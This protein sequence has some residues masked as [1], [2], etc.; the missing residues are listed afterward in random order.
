VKHIFKKLWNEFLLLLKPWTKTVV[1]FFHSK[2]GLKWTQKRFS[3][4]R[5]AKNGFSA[6]GRD[7]NG[8][9]GR[10]EVAAAAAAA[11]AAVSRSTGLQKS[12]NSSSS[13]S[14]RFEGG[15]IF[16]LFHG[17]ETRVRKNNPYLKFINLLQPFRAI[18]ARDLRG[19]F[20]PSIKVYVKKWVKIYACQRCGAQWT[21]KH[22]K[23]WKGRLL[24]LIFLWSS[25]ISFDPAYLSKPQP[26]IV[27]DPQNTGGGAAAR[28]F[29]RR[30]R[31]CRRPK[32]RLC[33]RKRDR[34][35]EVQWRRRPLPPGK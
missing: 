21:L 12:S 27:T 9:P 22:W 8:Q 14:S 28:G 24:F 34:K 25:L 1:P 5:S 32:C 2:M 10:G 29:D 7:K 20:P 33:M 30:R 31:R 3:C 18:N 35:G 11:A 16:Y 17:L 4:P 23:H 26:P 13:S 15:D 19:F 6:I